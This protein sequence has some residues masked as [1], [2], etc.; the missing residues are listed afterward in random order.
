[1][2]QLFWRLYFWR[3]NDAYELCKFQRNIA[4]SV[5]RETIIL[6]TIFTINSFLEVLICWIKFLS[7]FWYHVRITVSM[8][9]KIVEIYIMWK[10]EIYHKSLK[11][12]HWLSMC[13]VYFFYKD[14]R[15]FYRENAT[16]YYRSSNRKKNIFIQYRWYLLKYLSIIALIKFCLSLFF[17]NGL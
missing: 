11:Y 2:Y 15:S 9:N 16:A 6:G 1:M 8:M 12:K 5:N 4:A 7:K 13:V 14:W 10:Y 3:N 17:C